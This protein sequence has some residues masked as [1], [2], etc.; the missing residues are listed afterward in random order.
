MA[1]NTN[2]H[3]KITNKALLMKGS[4]PNSDF[5]ILDPKSQVNINIM[6][7]IKLFTNP[8]MFSG[9]LYITHAQTR[10]AIMV[11]NHTSGV[12]AAPILRVKP[13]ISSDF[14]NL[15]MRLRS[16]IRLPRARIIPTNTKKS[17]DMGLAKNCSFK[18]GR[19]SRAVKASLA[20]KVSIFPIAMEYFP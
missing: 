14:L 15:S 4:L 3:H 11:P 16:A 2:I 7:N 13:V 19:V 20:G 10:A 8:R 18:R 12:N 9:F 17:L 1:K 5:L 6:I